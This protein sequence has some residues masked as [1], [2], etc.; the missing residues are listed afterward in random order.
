MAT[1][2][3]DAVN[4]KIIVT[5]NTTT[6]FQDIY[7]A[8]VANGWNQVTKQGDNQFFFDCHLQIGDGSTSTNVSDRN[9]HVEIGTSAANKHMNVTANATF[10]FGTSTTPQNGGA[11]I[12]NGGSGVPGAPSSRWYG[13]TNFYGLAVL[14]ISSAWLN[15][16]GTDNW[17]N[18]V[19]YGTLTKVNFRGS[20]N[21]KNVSASFIYPQSSNYVFENCVFEGDT[22]G[23][24]LRVSSG[25]S[26]VVKDSEI[27]N[28]NAGGSEI[29]HWGGF[30]GT[31]N[32]IDCITNPDNWQWRPGANGITNLKYTVNV[33]V[34]DKDGNALSGVTVTLNDVDGNQIFSLTTDANGEI[35][36]QTVT[37]KTY[38]GDT[39]TIDNNNPFTLT[40][41]KAGYQ[42]YVKKFV[43]EEKAKWEIKLAKAVGVFLDFG[44]PVINLKKSDPENKN[45]VVL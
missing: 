1:I 24:V 30:T 9:K 37:S 23:A 11:V 3:Y 17:E 38:T 15:F 25:Y 27:I 42:T 34:T 22:S 14:K 20:G 45:V 26:V 5:G 41:E 44:R 28:N 35:T 36:E 4:D 40:I 19:L 12:I 7:D 21:F 13:T 43:L 16:Y 29:Q 6:L 10:T 33:K 18:I 32:V 2:T 8:D 39:P 31:L